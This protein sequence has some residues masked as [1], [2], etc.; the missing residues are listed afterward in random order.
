MGTTDDSLEFKQARFPIH[1]ELPPGSGE[2][3]ASAA[4]AIRREYRKSVSWKRLQ[5]QRVSPHPSHDGIHCLE[6]GQAMEFDWT[7]EGAV[8][9]KPLDDAALRNDP[10]RSLKMDADDQ[11]VEDGLLWSG[12]V[13]E[14]DDGRGH[15]YVGIENPEVKPT[16]GIFYVR[17]FEFLACLNE[18]FNSAA[19]DKLRP[20]LAPRLKAA[21]GGVHPRVAQCVPAGLPHLKEWWKYAWSVIWGPPGTG[22]TY[23]TGQQVARVLED[24]SERVLVVSTTN[25]ATDASALAIGRAAK[26]VARSE[27]SKGKLL[28]IGKGATLRQFE[29]EALTD[30]LRGTDTDY[31]ARIERLREELVRTTDPALRAPLMQTIAALRREMRDAA[32]QAFLNERNRAVVCTA[33]KAVSLLCEDEVKNAVAAGVAPFTTL[34]I[35]EAGL[36]SRAAIAALSLLASRRVV[37]VGDSRQLAPISQ[38]SRILPSDQMKWLASS[39]VSHLEH[40]GATE[41]AV[42]PLTVQRRMHA[43][44]CKAVSQFQYDGRLTTAPEVADRKYDLPEILKGHPRTLW[45]VLDETTDNLPD[46]RAERGPGNRS[47]VRVATESVLDKLFKDERVANAHG[48]FISPFKAQARGVSEYLAKK[49]LHGWTASTVHSQQGSEADIVIFDTVNAGSHGWPYDE[50]RRLVNVGISRAREG[51][52]LLASR[53]EMTEPYLRPLVKTLSPAVL[54]W[55]GNR[56]VFEAVPG[57][58]Q[59]ASLAPARAADPHSLGAQIEK[60]KQLRP[61]L[62]NEQQRLC[63]Y[64][65]DGKPRLVRGVAGSGKTVVLSHW[66]AKTVQGLQPGQR[67]RVWVVFANKALKRLIE[68]TVEQAWREEGGQGDFPWHTVDLFHVLDVLEQMRIEAAINGWQGD[69]YDYDS[70]ASQV[71]ARRPVG[72]LAQRCDALFIDE[73][74]DM[75][76]N[77]LKM[78]FG[79]VRQTDPADAN[80]RAVHVFYDNAQNVYGRGTPTWT[81]LGLNMQGRSAVMKKSF[82]S[83]QPIA[84]FGLNVL[85]QLNPPA[86][87]SDHRELVERRLVEAC[88]IDGV[89]WWKVRFNQVGGPKPFVAIHATEAEEYSAIAKEVCRLVFDEG[90]LPADICLVFMDKRVEAAIQQYLNPLLMR[91]Q[92]QVVAQR[93]NLTPLGPKEIRAT[94][95]HSFKGYD[96]EIVIV[97]S[98]NYYRAKG[99]ALGSAL[100]VALTRAR[101]LLYVHGHHD[102]QAAGGNILSVLQA[103]DRVL[104]TRLSDGDDHGDADR[105]EDLVRAIGEEHREWLVR[106]EKTHDLKREPLKYKRKVVVEPVFHFQARGK[107][108]I[109]LGRNPPSASVLEALKQFKMQ[110]I[111]PGEAI[112]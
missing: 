93:I 64:T 101:S 56:W 38:M 68:A 43:D 53:A 62:S 81:Q 89:D 2:D 47:W 109:C 19:F 95:P 94:T 41:E 98:A 78:L 73:A 12:E 85:C 54:R 84:E 31:L 82:R 45:Y 4:E 39:G 76:P 108:C 20:L 42:H 105:V 17:P 91:R 83:S 106:L 36:M 80:S 87:D 55:K 112:A 67:L 71:L 23:T 107:T 110:I 35:D 50:W 3:L 66:L 48:L 5:C 102:G 65:L 99:A 57:R 100:Y 26:D 13:L 61:I 58:V 32:K 24:P 74:Q 103:C 92:L 49:H 16:T 25:K 90:V 37:L 72:S 15:L 6:I 96:A 18:V 111:R 51:L 7:W 63:G 88:N 11:L 40:F 86:A 79:L 9:F 59:P 33:F 29:E 10:T 60:R 46:I 75:G 104:G 30:M 70:K 52:I 8:A 21:E 27:L 34:F 44:I 28:R 22:K 97:P 69:P 77:T 1:L 14:V